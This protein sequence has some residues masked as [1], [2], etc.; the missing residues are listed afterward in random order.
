LF[1]KK[2]KRKKEG[3]GH[4]LGSKRAQG[5]PLMSECRG[6]LLKMPSRSILLLFVNDLVK[7]KMQVKKGVICHVLP[8][9][10]GLTNAWIAEGKLNRGLPKSKY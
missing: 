7:C 3:A 9:L 4:P 1:K 6:A 2:G 5:R 10:K 8:A